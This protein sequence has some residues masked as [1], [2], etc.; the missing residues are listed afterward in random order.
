M[1][2]RLAAVLGLLGLCRP[3]LS[4]LGVHDSGPLTAP[5]G[6]LLL[7]A[8]ISV[9]WISATV[10]RDVPDPVLTLVGAGLAYA[11]FAVALNLSRQP[12]GNRSS[13]TRS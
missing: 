2:V 9:V 3:I 12:S 1:N 8:L 4:I 10:L 6:P 7:T 5:V 13:P 11:L